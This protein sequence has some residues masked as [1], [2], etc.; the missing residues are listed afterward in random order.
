L[1]YVKASVFLPKNLV[2]S[3]SLSGGGYSLFN[4]GWDLGWY[5]SHYQVSFGTHNLMGLIAPTA[6]PSTS[7]DLR[8]SYRF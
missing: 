4:V 3:V 2:T 1:G 7:L 6:Y 8:F 5:V